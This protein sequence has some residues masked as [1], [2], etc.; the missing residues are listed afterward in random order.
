M[1]AGAPAGW[2]TWIIDERSPAAGC[3]TTGLQISARVVD[4]RLLKY[5][6]S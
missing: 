1:A 6:D 3:S 5:N 2:D 4:L